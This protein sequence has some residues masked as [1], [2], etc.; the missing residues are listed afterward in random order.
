MI[1]DFNKLAILLVNNKIFS[2]VSDLHGIISGQLCAGGKEGDVLLTWHLM[3]Q[4]NKPSKIMSDLI[5]RLHLN[6]KEQ[7]TADD[8]S[9]QPLL[10]D[11]EELSLRLHAMSNWC[12]GFISGFGAAYAKGNRILL[13][14]TREVLNDYTAIANVD[15]NEQEQIENDEQD[16]M[17]VLEYVRMAAYSVFLENKPEKISTVLNASDSN[18]LH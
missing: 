6:I 18:S 15:D 13:E 8:F 12:E 11:D 7:L 10:P 16:F 1:P 4:E 14:E 9:F 2:S 5:I 3:G 17:E